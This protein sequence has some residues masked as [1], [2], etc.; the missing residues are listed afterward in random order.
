MPSLRLINRTSDFV[1]CWYSPHQWYHVSMWRCVN[2][3]KYSGQYG[4]SVLGYAWMHQFAWKGAESV[5]LRC[6]GTCAVWFLTFPCLC[7]KQ[8]DAS[9][10]GK[11]LLSRRWVTKYGAIFAHSVH[12][13]EYWL[14]GVRRW[15]CDLVCGFRAYRGREL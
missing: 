10:C 7:Q 5:V 13:L 8:F 4:F 12:V 3:F 11:R 1:W 9:T 15:L 14:E 6:I 2:W